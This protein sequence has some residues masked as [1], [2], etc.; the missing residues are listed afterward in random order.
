MRKKGNFVI[1][2]IGNSKFSSSRTKIHSDDFDNCEN[3]FRRE[4]NF[5][6]SWIGT[7]LIIWQ[8]FF[9]NRER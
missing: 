5:G 4:M 2:E 1:N 6:D 3:R 8:N 7:L 9:V